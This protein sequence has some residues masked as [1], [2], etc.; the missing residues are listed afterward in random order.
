M[1]Y[2][3]RRGYWKFQKDGTVNL[4]TFVKLKI[5]F[6]LQ[7]TIVCTFEGYSLATFLSESSSPVFLARQSTITAVFL[8]SLL[9]PTLYCWSIA[10]GSQAVKDTIRQFIT[11]RLS[12]QSLYHW[13]CTRY[14]TGWLF[15]LFFFY[16]RVMTSLFGVYKRVRK[17]VIHVFKKA[18]Q[19]ILNNKTI[20]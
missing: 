16:G 15:G 6:P 14:G 10:E 4:H 13:G 19:N 11:Y 2:P 7:I 17:T 20:S 5:L 8:N 9:N 3:Y 18:F 12:H 1:E